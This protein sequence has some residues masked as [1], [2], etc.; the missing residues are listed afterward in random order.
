[1]LFT[2]FMARSFVGIA[3]EAKNIYPN[4]ER[5]TALSDSVVISSK[6]ADSELKQMSRNPSG[7]SVK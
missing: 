1:M 4:G 6:K 7:D 2:E 3:L 5:R